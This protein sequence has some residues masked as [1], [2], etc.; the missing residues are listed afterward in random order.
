MIETKAQA[1]AQVVQR[2]L[3]IALVSEKGV[4][5]LDFGQA[6]GLAEALQPRS[7]ELLGLLE[8]LG[9][10]KVEAMVVVIILGARD[11][12]PQ[13]YRT[14]FGEGEVLDVPNFATGRPRAEEDS[15]HHP[16]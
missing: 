7:R 16:D 12:L 6:G 11:K 9:V 13:A 4:A 2:A 8:L 10:E 5:S 3:W 1:V 15:R 14:V